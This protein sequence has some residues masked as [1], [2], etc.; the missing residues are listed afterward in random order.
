MTAP[1]TSVRLVDTST[2]DGNQSLWGAA[3]L[4]TGMVEALAPHLEAAGFLA[5]DFTSST[6]L[7]V[8]VRWHHE[9]PWERIRRMRALT[10]GTPLAL[11]TTGM[12]FMSW[13]R[14]PQSVM[15]L[16]MRMLAESG[17]R[18]LQIAEPMNDTAQASAIARLAKEEGIEQ[19]VA[20]VTFTESPVH[21]DALYAA[22][23]KTLA[24]DENVDAIYLKDPGG[25]L[26]PERTR[27][28]VPQLRAASGDRSLELHSHCTTGLAPEVYVVAAQLGIDVLHTALGALSNGT[29]QPSAVRLVE[30][31]AAV[32]IGTDIELGPLHEAER[33]IGVIASSQ[34]LEP[35]RPTELDLAYQRHQV[36]GGMMGTLRRQLSEIGQLDL[37]PAVLDEVGSVRAA[38]GYPIMVTPYSQF[39]G[40]QA[41][42]NVLARQAGQ[43]PWSRMPDEVLRYLLG[44]FGEPPG[45]VDPEVA[46][47]AADNPR[48]RE[49]DRPQA[50][51]E[52]A[53]LRASVVEQ[54]GRADV[55]DGEVL[56]R[57]VLPAEQVDAIVTPAPAWSA[58]AAGNDVTSAAEFVRAAGALP[59]WREIDVRLGDE[60][61]HLRREGAS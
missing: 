38:L 32:G 29:S 3:G 18:R 52:L 56:L 6:H 34:G 19:V 5:L 48:T 1:A 49:L 4:T 21:D 14:S 51:P 22:A 50:E 11:I 2:R 20:A 31:L 41:V 58:E 27:T 43:E 37:L 39:V 12:R 44:H 28:L 13:D 59:N 40:S 23:A 25:L 53:D 35:G 15:R 10:P 55:G 36:P 26:T 8:G 33:I 45:P 42:M 46:S 30:N 9:D 60:R 7:S 54:T 24:A 57:T 47:R 16:S 61:V 17:L